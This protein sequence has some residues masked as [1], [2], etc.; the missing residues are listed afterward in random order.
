MCLVSR[1]SADRRFACSLLPCLSLRRIVWHI[2]RAVSVARALS[3]P[4]KAAA[5]SKS[6]NGNRAFGAQLTVPWLQCTTVLASR[7][8]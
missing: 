8:S 3:A 5:Q 4:S 1:A 6:S 2:E 7:Q